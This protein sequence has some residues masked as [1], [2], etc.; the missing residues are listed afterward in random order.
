MLFVYYYLKIFFVYATKK[1]Q[2]YN[3]LSN[4][5]LLKIVLDTKIVCWGEN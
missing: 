5:Q 1:F 4:N 2:A 3:K